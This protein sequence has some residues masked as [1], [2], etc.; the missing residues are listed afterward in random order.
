MAKAKQQKA[1]EAPVEASTLKVDL[2]IKQM[3][4]LKHLG[5]LPSRPELVLTKKAQEA[6]KRLML[7]LERDEAKLSDGSQV[8]TSVPKAIVWLCERLSEV[9]DE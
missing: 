3:V 5:Y 7:T 9:C 1:V 6:V 8:R 4:D 2:G